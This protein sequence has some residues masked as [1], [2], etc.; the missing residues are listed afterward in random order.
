MLRLKCTTF[1]FESAVRV[2]YCGIPDILSRFQ[3]SYVYGEKMRRQK[4]KKK[5]KR[6]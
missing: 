4:R 5:I 2:A 6:G 1:D 3:R